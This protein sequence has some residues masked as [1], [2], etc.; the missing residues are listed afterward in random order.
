MA[1]QEKKVSV[2]TGMFEVEFV[3]DF[4]SYT[5]GDKAIYHAST[6]KNLEK[7]EHVK[8]LKEIKKYVPKTMKE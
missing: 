6:A 1:K 3:K 7:K 4:G 2:G 5:A 8:I